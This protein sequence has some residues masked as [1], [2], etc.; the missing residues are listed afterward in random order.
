MESLRTATSRRS[1]DRKFF[2]QLALGNQEPG[3]GKIGM[4]ERFGIDRSQATA[5]EMD[6]DGRAMVGGL[7]AAGIMGHL[8]ISRCPVLAHRRDDAGGG[9]GGKPHR[10]Q[11]GE[12]SQ[13]SQQASRTHDAHPAQLRRK[14]CDE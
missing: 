8:L 5:A 6:A 7:Y 10:T 3:H 2:D 9:S 1:D 14:A 12:E 13:E 11:D 4:S